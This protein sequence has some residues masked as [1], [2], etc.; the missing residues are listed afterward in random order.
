MSGLIVLNNESNGWPQSVKQMAMGLDINASDIFFLVG[1]NHHVVLNESWN[2]FWLTSGWP[3]LHHTGFV[4]EPILQKSL[5]S[6]YYI[7]SCCSWLKNNNQIRSQFCT[8]HDNSV[9]VTCA[10]LW[11]D[12]IIRI[13]IKTKRIS[14]RFQLEAHNSVSQESLPQDGSVQPGP[15]LPMVQDS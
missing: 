5:R 10:K 2:L 7:D 13:I 8:C 14:E 12:W 11:P 4:Q 6:K 1:A 15:G 9:V 3:I